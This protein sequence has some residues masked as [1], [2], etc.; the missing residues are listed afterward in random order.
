MH[1]LDVLGDPVRRRL[2]EL[3]AQG[4]K[5]AG[6]LTDVV[7]DEF[8]ISQPAVSNHL[9]V[10]RDAGFARS[11]PAGSRR[12]YALQAERMTE[13]QQWV[14]AQVAFWLTRLDA[15]DTELHRGRRAASEEES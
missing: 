2:V 13:A 15:L 3:L 12:I 5:A 6:E 11:M 7:R 8:G 9:K 4:D 1:A 14:D 10:L